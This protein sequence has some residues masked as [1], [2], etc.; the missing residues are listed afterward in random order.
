MSKIKAAEF[1]FNKD[2]KRPDDVH[3]AVRDTKGRLWQRYSTMPIGVWGEIPLP[4]E[5]KPAIN[6]RRKRSSKPPL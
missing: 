2:P 1:R 3:L 4:D 5:P 6:R